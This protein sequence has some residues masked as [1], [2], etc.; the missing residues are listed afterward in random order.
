MSRIFP[1][2][3]V[4]F[5]TGNLFILYINFGKKHQ[6]YE[7]TVQ[8]PLDQFQC[9][10]DFLH[11]EWVF[12]AHEKALTSNPSNM[13]RRF[14]RG[15]VIF[16]TGDLFFI[17]INFGKKIIFTSLPFKSHWTNFNANSILYNFRGYSLHMKRP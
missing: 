9:K 10:F 16:C 7:P 14:P 2:G 12:F 3:L 13:S 15:L 6:F 1:R 8:K 11:L 17:Y 5:C 4:I